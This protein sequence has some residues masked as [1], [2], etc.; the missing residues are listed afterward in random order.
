M[1]F[2][3]LPLINRL[4]SRWV[5]VIVCGSRSADLDFRA[6]MHMDIALGRGRHRRKSIRESLPHLGF[7]RDLPFLDDHR[8]SVGDAAKTP[9][10][11][12]PSMTT[13]AAE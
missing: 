1:V 7:F 12:M 10:A 8:V 5:K 2:I 13:P 6:S 4:V 11:A 9:V 3:F